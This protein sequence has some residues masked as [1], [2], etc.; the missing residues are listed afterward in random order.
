MTPCRYF[1]HNYVLNLIFFQLRG[2]KFPE[3]FLGI[4]SL[5]SQEYH[6]SIE[7]L[8]NSHCLILPAQNEANYMKIHEKFIESRK[9]KFCTI[10]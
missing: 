8:R 6:N 7:L 9:L 2:S 5:L 10:L 4:K 3:F 1:L